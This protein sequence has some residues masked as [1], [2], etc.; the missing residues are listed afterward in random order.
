MKRDNKGKFKKISDEDFLTRV[1][2]IS[3]YIKIKSKYNGSRSNIKCECEKC[4]NKWATQARNLLRGN[5]CPKCNKSNPKLN[6]QEYKNQIKEINSNIIVLGKYEGNKER[7][8]C[9]C[10]VCGYK[11]NPFASTLKQKH[12][13]P[14]CKANNDR[15]TNEEFI[16]RVNKINP[17]FEILETYVTYKTLIKVKC[18]KCG[19]EFETTPNKILKGINVCKNCYKKSLYK[20]SEDYRKELKVKNPYVIQLED[21]KGVNIKLKVKCSS[22]GNIWEASPSGLLCGF[23]CPLCKLSHG[24]KKIKNILDENNIVYKIQK[25]FDNLLGIKGKPLSYDFYLPDYNL[26]IEYQGKQH[27]MPIK[28]F[29]GEKQFK[30]QQE[31]DKRKK[32]YAISNNINLLEI[33]YNEN[34]EEKLKN[35]LNLE[36]LETAGC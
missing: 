34:I 10:K 20:K 13:C 22:C 17:S 19:E 31:H 24:E 11:W 27:K 18:L 36:T 5:G 28:Y 6:T 30:I 12:G 29:G 8:Q 33:W 23:G 16:E 35:S 1:S 2:K 7:I 9:K 3:S 21:Y 4:G 26:L 32:E 15:L 14:N 25:K